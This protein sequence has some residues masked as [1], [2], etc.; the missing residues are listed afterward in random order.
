MMNIILSI[1]L[2]VAV[3][4]SIMLYMRKCPSTG[5]CPPCS[6]GVCPVD[7]LCPSCPS[8]G[9][10]PVNPSS[11]LCPSCPP[12]RKCP[13]PM[14]DLLKP[15]VFLVSAR[16]G[17]DI[18]DSYSDSDLTEIIKELSKNGSDYRIATKSELVDSMMV[19]ASE[20]GSGWVSVP[21]VGAKFEKAY[22]TNIG[23]RYPKG[24]WGS[25]ACTKSRGGSGCACGPNKELFSYDNVYGYWIFGIKPVTHVLDSKWKIE[26]FSKEHNGYG[27]S[28]WSQWS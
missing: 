21:G 23:D 24:S 8:G 14:S 19:G 1:L 13:S 25:D 22:P 2:I 3:A 18:G 12:Q 20:C 27:F 10:C 26:A 6:K 7:G 28:K 9:M 5:L 16:K 17:N 4:I 15:E 11:G